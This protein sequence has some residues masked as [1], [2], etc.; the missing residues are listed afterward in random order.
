MLL[1]TGW[2]FV[3]SIMDIRSRRLP[4]WMLGLGGV[5]TIL[6]ALY[7]DNTCFEVLR[8]MLPGVVLLLIAFGTK[9]AGYGDGIVMVFLGMLLGGEKSLML[10]GFSLFLISVFALV[11]LALRKVGRNTGMPFLPFLTVAWTV[12]I[13]L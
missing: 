11:L 8:G 1:V 10:F 13:N 12:M 4:I 2:M 5:L 3:S 7:Q 9:K 6:T